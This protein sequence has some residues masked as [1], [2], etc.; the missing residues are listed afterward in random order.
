MVIDNL[1]S[2]YRWL[3]P[4]DDRIVFIEDD[5][6]GRALES[7]EEKDAFVFH[8]AAFFANQNSVDHP[9]DD[10]HTNGLGTLKVLKWAAKNRCRRV[11]YASAVLDQPATARTA[12][13]RGYAGEPH[14][15]TRTR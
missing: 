15:D 5:I 1:A 14:L 10:L 8:L 12:H 7:L 2:G 4:E 6:A 3:L 13:T 9:E 11:I